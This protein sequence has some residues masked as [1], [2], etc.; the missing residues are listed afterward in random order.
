MMN[1]PSPAER[2][3][4]QSVA[5]QQPYFFPY[6]GYFALIQQTDFFVAFDPVQYIRKGWMNRNRVLKPVEGWQYLTAPMQTHAQEALI[7]EVQVQAGA[8]WKVKI[9]RQLEHYKKRAPHYAAVMSL[10]ETCF[11]NADTSLSR[12][13]VYYLEQTCAYL[14]LPFRHAIFSDLHL[15]LAPVA[16]PDEW[17]LRIAQALGAKSYV[18]QPG[19]RS[20]FDSAKYQAAGIELQFND[21]E[22]L[23]YSQRRDIFEPGLSIIDVLM[24]NTP[25]Q[26]MELLS[27]AQLNP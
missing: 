7:S 20:F 4:I 8:E 13:N 14:G 6:L 19:G 16:A 18:N 21:F 25:A 17:A 12:L 2:P 27:G 26:V 5:I 15:E 9:M 22:V 3:A 11:A 1:F 23:P 24:F 10:L